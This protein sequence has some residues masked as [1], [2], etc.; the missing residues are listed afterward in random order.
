[1]CSLQS[2]SAACYG[3]VYQRGARVAGA[4]RQ[5]QPDQKAPQNFRPDS[6][7]QEN[8]RRTFAVSK[9]R[10]ISCHSRLD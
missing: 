8:T 9:I 2:D 7:N 6:R 1:M 5:W 3:V 10:G 4:Y